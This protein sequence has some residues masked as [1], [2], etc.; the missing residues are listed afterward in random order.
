M[1]NSHTTLTSLFTAI[2]NAIRDRKGSS[3][4]IVADNFP[5]EIMSILKPSGT[6]NLSYT[7][8]GTYTENIKNY[9]SASIEVNVSGGSPSGTKTINI[10][11]NGTTTHDVASYAN[12]QIVT[13][14]QAGGPGVS[15]I[16]STILPRSTGTTN[17]QTNAGNTYAFYTVEI[18]DATI[19]FKPDFFMVINE[20]QTILA[21]VYNSK[22]Y[23][24]SGTAH[25]VCLT[26]MDTTQGN[27]IGEWQVYNDTTH[28]WKIPIPQGN[29]P[30]ADTNWRFVA[31]QFP[32]NS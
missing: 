1:P 4:Q 19:G 18:S 31:G 23:D 25:Y 29:E 11:T 28:T 7:T 14:V 32:A 27:A 16:Y 22:A 26:M 15:N 8:N 17:L 13:N 9:A 2:A 5:S 6:K 3:S 12:A 10:D 21:S 24:Q 20:K 30:T